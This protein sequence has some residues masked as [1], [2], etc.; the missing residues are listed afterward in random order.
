M[1]ITFNFWVHMRQ[2]IRVKD[3]F[4][5]A[6]FDIFILYCLRY[7]YIITVDELNLLLLY[8]NFVRKKSADANLQV[9]DVDG[10]DLFPFFAL[11]KKFLVFNIRMHGNAIL[12]FQTVPHPIWGTFNKNGKY[13]PGLKYVRYQMWP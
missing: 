6:L 4:F 9:C 12:M 3:N 13:Q 2:N 10:L 7:I 8:K 11:V 5:H 1:R